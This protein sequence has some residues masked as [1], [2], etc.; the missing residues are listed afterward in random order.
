V[1]KHPQFLSNIDYKVQPFLVAIMIAG[2]TIQVLYRFVPFLKVSWALEFNSFMFSSFVWCGISLAIKE[3]A[4]MGL[5]SFIEL[6]PKKAYKKITVIQTLLFGIYIICI[7]VLGIKY[8]IEV[9]LSGM[10]T[11]G[12]RVPYYIVRLPFLVGCIASLCRLK[13]KLKRDL[14][15]MNK[16]DM[17]RDYK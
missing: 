6:L 8:F 13:E 10:K 5:T 4:H 17:H 2:V 7:G 16:K 11:P 9:Y 1:K 3:D 15:D 14:C 12:M